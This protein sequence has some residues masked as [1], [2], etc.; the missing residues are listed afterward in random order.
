MQPGQVFESSL[1]GHFLIAMPSLADPNFSY[2]VSYIAEHTSDGAM[3]LVINRVHPELSM[4]IVFDELALNAVPDIAD[5]PLHLGGPV[6]TE[7]VFILHGPP[8]GWEACQQV[9]PNIALS[10]SM[11]LIERVAQGRGPGSF[12]CALGCA[13]WGPGQL[14]SEIMANAWLSCPAAETI[15]FDVA[16][17]NRWAEAAKLLGIDPNRLTDVSGHA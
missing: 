7:Q 13:G 6:H 10:N 12:V 17:E 14:E 15:L 8:F 4:R 2:T 5:L 11:D 3:G 1:K 9:T 16:V